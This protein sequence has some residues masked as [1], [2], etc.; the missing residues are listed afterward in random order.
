MQPMPALAPHLKQLRL[1]RIL[2]SLE[3]R[4]RQALD[5]QLSY[6]D[7]LAMLLVRRPP[8]ALETGQQ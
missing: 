7:F 8:R 3:A 2:D 1:F 5:A 6:V 4:N